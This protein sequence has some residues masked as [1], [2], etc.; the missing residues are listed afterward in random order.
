MKIKF[1]NIAL[2]VICSVFTFATKAQLWEVVGSIG[3][4]QE[5]AYPTIVVDDLTGTPYMVDRGPGNAPKVFGFDG[6]GWNE[7]AGSGN[8][9]G[10]L[11]VKCLAVYNGELYLAYSDINA[12][13][14]ATVKKYNGTN[15]EL[16]GTAGFTSAAIQSMQIEVDNGIPYVAFSTNQGTTNTSVMKFD[17]V[18]W[19]YVGLPSFTAG[20]NDSEGFI[21]ENGIPY[22]AFK[23][24]AYND[25]IT[26][27]K[28]N[29]L[30]WEL[31]GSAG[32]TSGSPLYTV[33]LALNNGVPYIAYKDNSNGGHVTVMNFDG[34]NWNLV[35]NAGFSPN[36]GSFVNL[37][38]YNGEP[39]VM[40]HAA[41]TNVMKFDG[42]SWVQVG[43]ANFSAGGALYSGMTIFDDFAYVAYKD[44]STEGGTVM[45]YDL[46]PLANLENNLIL[47]QTILVYPTPSSGIVF[48]KSEIDV[49]NVEVIDLTGKVLKVNFDTDQG[50]IDASDL[51]PGTYF[52]IL[53]TQQGTVKKELIITD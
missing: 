18:N 9:S 1:F 25:K 45:M 8:A 21:V 41:K 50:V 17:G 40:Y 34:V 42:T 22:L 23:D 14:K 46:R 28:F 33:S 35:G 26:V 5:G 6:N 2:G 7:V 3:F 4:T 39:F 12:G 19:V 13:Y 29:G 10:L 49:L 48:I 11:F 27:M 36:P 37:T 53:Q 43:N 51:A 32:F 15:W 38:I 44:L 47:N 30:D 31:M 24:A 16:V 52:L 20:G